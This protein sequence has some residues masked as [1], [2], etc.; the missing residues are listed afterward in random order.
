MRETSLSRRDVTLLDLVDSILRRG[1]VLSGDLTLAVADVDLVQL[2]LRALLASVE[3][4]RRLDAAAPG[5][6]A[7]QRAIQ[8][9]GAAPSRRDE[10]ATSPAGPVPVGP[11]G[12][13]P[14]SAPRPARPARRRSAP[15]L[16]GR[17]SRKRDLRIDTDPENVERG[18]AQLVLTVIELLRQ[19]MERQALYRMESGSL[20]EDEVERLGQT[21]LKLEERMEQLKR[22]FGLEDEELNLH[23]GP[24]GDLM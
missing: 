21:F 11:G 14:T 7:P 8:A 3:T 24:L 15:V 13:T 6:R 9:D 19:L 2:N 12:P 4:V 10:K 1:V 17:S 22:D 5:R 16:H 23:L 20:T 18:L